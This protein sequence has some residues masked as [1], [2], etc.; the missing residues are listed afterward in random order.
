RLRAELRAHPCHGCP[1]REDHARWAER[2]FKLHRDS[3]T[4][5]RRIEQRTNSI[6]RQFDRVCDV[7][8]DLGYLEE[9]ETA[10]GEADDEAGRRTLVTPRGARLMRLYSDLDLV[11][12][13][14]L[15][16]GLWDA[17]N[18]SELAAVLS[19]L[20]FEARRPEDAGAPRLPGGRVRPA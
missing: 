14:A 13:E 18:P 1:D 15:R 17:L 11:A 5:A 7:L 2:H 20:A 16:E 12:A 19:T 8:T 10:P 3:Q 6:A 4:L 9:V